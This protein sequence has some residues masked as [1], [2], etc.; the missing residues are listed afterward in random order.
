MILQILKM[1]DKLCRLCA[2]EK[3]N[4]LAICEE[5]GIKQELSIKIIQ[6]LQIRIF[7]EDQLPK[8]VCVDCCNKL[9]QTSEFLNSCSEAQKLL[10]AILNSRKEISANSVDFCNN[11]PLHLKNHDDQEHFSLEFESRNNTGVSSPSIQEVQENKKENIQINNK[12]INTCKLTITKKSIEKFEEREDKQK[13][14]RLEKIYTWQCTDCPAVLA[15]RHELEAHHCDVHNQLPRFQCVDCAKVFTAYMKLSRHVRLHRNHGK[16]RCD[17]CNKSFSSKQSLGNHSVLHEETRPYSCSDC[18]KAFHQI[19]SLYCHQQI[20][21]TVQHGLPCSDCG[22]LFKTLYLLNKHKATHSDIKAHQC[23]VC[24]KQFRESSTLK[25][26]LRIHTDAMPYCCEFC[27][28]KFRFQGVYVIHRRQHTGE[29][30]YSCSVCQQEFTNWANYNKHT[31]SQHQNSSN[32]SGKQV[33]NVSHSPILSNLKSQIVASAE[34]DNMTSLCPLQDT[35][36]TDVPPAVSEEKLENSQ[37][38]SQIISGSDLT[39]Y[40]I[41]GIYRNRWTESLRGSFI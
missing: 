31:K 13:R 3:K 26:H 8:T 21:Q 37:M 20:H 25:L 17:E 18:G 11:E 14:I 28:R 30:P 12:N 40:Y 2:K 33:L 36:K 22:K 39:N 24:G 10:Q 27:G 5:E 23:D 15:T 41:S 29:H 19:E 38:D 35:Y 32:N 9:H 4:M 34:V 16:Y 1:L 7:P 6:Y